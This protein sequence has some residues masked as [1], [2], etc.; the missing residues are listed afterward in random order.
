M[1][2]VMASVFIVLCVVTA[3]Q[4]YWFSKNVMSSDHSSAEL[5]LPMPPEDSGG[6]KLALR[7]VNAKRGGGR[8]G[9]I[10]SD[11]LEKSNTTTRNQS[12]G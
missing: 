2:N 11:T 10:R 3:T 9:T 12:H 7:N 6:G 4:W 8:A 5:I 1:R